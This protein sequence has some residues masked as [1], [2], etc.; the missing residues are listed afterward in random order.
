[1]KLHGGL[2]LGLKWTPTFLLVSVEELMWLE[3]LASFISTSGTS[4]R[5]VICINFSVSLC[6]MIQLYIFC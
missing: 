4:G 2:K 1:M 6:F 3:G 5:E